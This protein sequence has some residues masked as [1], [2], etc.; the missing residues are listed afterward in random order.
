MPF[1]QHMPLLTELG[2]ISI[3][4]TFKH[5]AP[6]ALKAERV[7]HDD[8][9]HTPERVPYADK[10]L[11]RNRVSASCPR[12]TG[13]QPIRLSLSMNLHAFAGEKGIHWR[14]RRRSGSFCRSQGRLSVD[15]ILAAIRT[16]SSPS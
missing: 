15:M 10:A 13:W 11:P 1:Q 12:L 2:D 7:R 16:P 6:T 14:R 9:I 8:E 3:C 5:N 4:L